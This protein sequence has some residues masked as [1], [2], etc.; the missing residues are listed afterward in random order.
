M[1]REIARRSWMMLKALSLVLRERRYM[2]NWEILLR[3][4]QLEVDV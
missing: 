1:M 3:P 2:I 4:R